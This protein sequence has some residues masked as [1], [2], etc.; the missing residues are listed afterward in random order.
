M[1]SL[2]ASGNHVHQPSCGTLSD[3]MHLINNHVVDANDNGRSND[4]VV[5]D[6]DHVVVHNDHVAL[7]NMC[8]ALMTILS[9]IFVRFPKKRANQF[10]LR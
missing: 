4:H 9:C 5:D 8:V 7:S 3:H 6:N 1:W 10:I 2:H